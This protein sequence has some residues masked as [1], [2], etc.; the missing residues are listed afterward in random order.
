MSA[1][2]VPFLRSA[3][4]DEE[5]DALDPAETFH[6][7]SRL[8]PALTERQAAGIARLAASPPLQELA[9]RP[10]RRN[11]QL[12]SA[13]LTPTPLPAVALTDAIER[14]QSKPPG[15]G[16]PLPVETLAA[17]LHAAYGVT[18]SGRRTV[19]SG[20]ALYPLELFV[21]VRNVAG[22][23]QGVWHLDPRCSRLEQLP[24]REIELEAAVPLKELV[25]HASAVVFL[26]ATF[27]RT[28][29][30]YGLRGYRFA[31]LEAGHA[32][33]NLV[34][35]AAACGVNALPLGGFY[36]AV[37]DDLLGLDGVDQSVLYGVV[38]G[39]TP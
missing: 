9:A 17:L 37:V 28:R 38:L 16:S 32:A 14:R 39:G 34:L 7:A 8:Y 26:A 2:P 3:L 25:E 20:G 18:A 21:V 31:L 15:P 23:E 4:H 12:P 19:P 1:T 11:P 29:F 30:K 22:L 27:W 35:A 36:D 5:H 33:Q 10:V 24:P 6:E 13:E